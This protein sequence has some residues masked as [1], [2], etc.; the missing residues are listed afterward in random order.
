MKKI[1]QNRYVLLFFVFSLMLFTNRSF[2]QEAG[3]EIV[4]LHY[5]NSN[6][7]VQYLILESTLKKNK[8]FTPQK[9]KTYEIYLDSAATNLV[10]KVK[11]DAAGKKQSIFATNP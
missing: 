2:A 3:Q 11:T 10:A 1:N 7:S 5:Y 4:K 9:D 8:V 6:N